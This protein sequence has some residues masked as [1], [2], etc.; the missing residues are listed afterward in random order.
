[1]NSPN[2]KESYERLEFL[3]DAILEMLIST[4]LYHRH[5]DKMEG[6]LTA[7]RSSIVRT[8]SLSEICKSNGINKY[9]LMSKGEELSGGRENLSILEDII[10]SLMGAIYL[11]GGILAA[12]AF[13]DKF[14]SPKANVDISE[15]KLKDPKHFCKNQ[16]K[17]KGF[18]HQYTRP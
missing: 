2:T 1:L 4:F 6:F 3:G 11:D 15:D 9:I 16:S 12:Q 13:F 8:E 7:A 18:P 17:P 14:I 5:P 10:E